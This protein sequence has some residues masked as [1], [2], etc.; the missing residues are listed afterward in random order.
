MPDKKKVRKIKPWFNKALLISSG[1][2]SNLINISTINK[3]RN[4][5]NAYPVSLFKQGGTGK[6]DIICEKYKWNKT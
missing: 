6:D 5:C 4:D 3:G 2:S 1:N